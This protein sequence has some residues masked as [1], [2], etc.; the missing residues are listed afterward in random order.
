MLRNSFQASDATL[1]MEVANV[2]SLLTQLVALRDSG[3]AI[4]NEVKLVASSLQTEEKLFR[5]P[6]TTARKRMRFHDEDTPEEN[7]NET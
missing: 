3:K 2:E 1:D 7:V 6:S 5:I 4:W